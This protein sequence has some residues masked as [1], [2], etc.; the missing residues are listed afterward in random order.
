MKQLL[1]SLL[2]I[3]LFSSINLTAQSKL[4]QQVD[5]NSRGINGTRYIVPDKFITFKFDSDSF[6]EQFANVSGRNNA[7]TLDVPLPDGSFITFDLIETPVFDDELMRKYPGFTSYTGT[8]IQGDRLKM[9]LSPFGINAMIISDVHGHLFIDPITLHDHNDVY[10]VYD[11]RDFKKKTGNFTCGVAADDDFNKTISHNDTREMKGSRVGDCQLR[12]YRLAISC[13]GEY[14]TFHGGTKAKV[15]AAYNNTMTRVNGV[16]ETDAG[17]TMKLIGDTDKVIFLNGTTDPFNNAEGDVMLDQNQ[18]T[19]D[20]LIGKANYDIGHVFSTGG[21]GIAQLRSPCSTRK[22]MGVTGQP[23]PVGDPFDIDYVAHEMG[24]Q[25]GANHTQNNDCQRAGTASVEPGSASTIMG[26][27]G[28][29]DPNIQNNSDAYFNGINLSEIASFVVAG[30]GNTCAQIIPEMNSK[31]SVTILKTSYTIPVSTSFALTA[32]GNDADG[33]VLTY[34]WEQIDNEVATMPPT[35]SS[36]KGPTFRSLKPSLSPT[37]Y[38]PDLARKYGVWEVLPSVTRDLDFRCTVRDNH[39]KLGCTDE[40]N[41]TV[42]TNNSA[43]PFLVLYPN[44][45]SVSWLVGSSQTVRWDVAKTDVGPINCAQV[46]IYL[47]T[48][49]GVTYPVLLAQ[50]VTNNGSFEIT[51][52]GPAT[53]KAKI[54]VKAS[55]NIFFDVSNANF[56]II[57]SFTIDAEIKQK[58]ICNESSF[59][60]KLLLDSILQIG[61]PIELSILNPVSGLDYFFSLNPVN[62]VPSES[63]L[64]ITGLQSLPAGTHVVEVLAVSGMERLTAKIELFSGN[65]TVASFNTLYPI[66]NSLDVDPNKIN[67]T[68]ESISGIKDYNIE[69]ST[70]PAFSVVLHKATTA[71]NKYEYTLESG[72]VYFWRVKPN[73]PCINQPFGMTAS[74]RTTGSNSGT[75]I[76]LT[77]EGLLVN[78]TSAGFIDTTL[79]LVDGS[80]R[81]YITFTL[82]KIPSN[83]QLFVENQ[84]LALG[85]VFTMSDIASGKLKYQHGGSQSDK[86]EMIF[87]ILDDQGRWLPNVTF[88]IKINLGTIGVFA[89]KEQSILCYEEKTGVI[90]ADGY[91]GV[92]PYTYSID[93]QNYQSS[94]IFENLASGDYTISI[95]DDAGEIAESNTITLTQPTEIQLTLTTDKYDILVSASGGSGNWTYSLDNSDFV[96]EPKFNDPGNGRHVVAVRDSEGCIKTGEIEINIEPLSVIGK[97]N[98]DVVCA[99]Q[100]AALN[101]LASG[102]FKPYTFSADG[103]TYQASSL[104]NLQPGKYVIYV[105]DGG[106]KTATTDTLRTKTPSPIVVNLVQEKLKVTVLASGGTGNL[107]YSFNGVNYSENN[108]FEYSDNGGYKIYVRDSLSCTKITNLTLNVLKDLKLTIKNITCHNTTDGYI[109]IVASNGALPFRYSLNGGAF[110]STREWSNLNGGL[111]KYVVKDNKNDS[112]SGE[113]TIIRP[114]SLVLDYN[115]IGKDLELIVNGGTP[116][117]QYSIDNGFL[118]LEN[119]QFTDLDA[120]KYDVVVK[121][122]NGC[123][124]SR[125]ILLSSIDDEQKNTDILIYPNPTN[126]FVFLKSRVWNQSDKKIRFYNLE[127][128]EMVVETNIDQDLVKIDMRNLS[129]GVY[130]VKVIAGDHVITRKIVKE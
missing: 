97:I 87:N 47:S 122:A 68:W 78:Q 10:Q 96:T 24:H 43:G 91:G 94:E 71:A 59:T 77:N 109:K 111:Y 27:A 129:A 67:F 66:N 93:G 9:S 74:F 35:A 57:S 81:D 28:I 85:S 106:G 130:I 53:T 102:G 76:L 34:C 83:G 90:R 52:P 48:D 8:N 88:I 107:N 60:T 124:V 3:F 63:E 33:D 21:G 31:P 84:L 12:S 112:L 98:A 125:T 69:I 49:G 118:F 116:P 65:K 100:M 44:T 89:Y 54:M 7:S 45:T 127:G 113:I 121:D 62:S 16:Y 26:Y 46:D 117:F 55:D 32:S 37:R 92:K 105:K 5:F 30:N 39:S 18:T 128:K 108:T 14:A 2:L 40:I 86:D 58:N 75:A 19:I 6:R 70:T 61:S 23:K 1:V 126:G 104:F 11:K 101:G 4:W 22:A 17:I 123:N 95:K 51:V 80:N 42:K 41:V 50:N 82:T 56:K 73:S 114:D 110:S 103:Q 64:L 72:K 38:F 36:N 25:F 79:L 115:L 120:V 119:N 20:N 15:L 99:S 13:T 29:C